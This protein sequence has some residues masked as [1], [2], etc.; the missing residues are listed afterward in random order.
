MN[1]VY[2]V[3]L[4]LAEKLNGAKI[5]GQFAKDIL[6]LVSLLFGFWL[7]VLLALTPFYL[8]K[9]LFNRK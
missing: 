8:L 4:E 7:L 9:W 1:G 2:S 5:T 3:F 6:W